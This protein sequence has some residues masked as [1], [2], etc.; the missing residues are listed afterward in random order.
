MLQ[1]RGCVVLYG[2]A[3]EK[4]QP[5]IWNAR[6]IKEEQAPCWLNHHSTSKTVNILPP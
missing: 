2:I 4:N 5:A 3:M 1:M 6:H